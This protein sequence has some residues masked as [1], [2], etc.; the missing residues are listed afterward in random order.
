LGEVAW[1]ALPVLDETGTL[2]I[3]SLAS[4]E[5]WLDM[6]LSAAKP[7]ERQV[8]LRLQALNGAGVLD[9]PTHP[10]TVPPPE[11]SVEIALHVPAFAMAAPGDF[12]L[13]TWA[14]PDEAQL[15]DLLAHGNNVFAISLPAVNYDTQGRLGRS[16]YS[17][18]DPVLSRLRGQDVVLLLTGIP[19]LH[20]AP[21]SAAYRGDQKQ[22]LDE[23]VAHLAGAGFN[24]KHFALYPFDEP[25]GVG[26]SLINQLVE[27][28]KL[29]RAANPEVMIYVDGGGELSMF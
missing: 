3:P 19:S 13:C 26:W 24:T 5:L 9:A 22:F 10:H 14:A 23:L 15:P 29:V 25:G 7:G 6:D 12:R 17:K 28:G 11:T 16:D 2:S 20:G 18:L 4:R 8:K 1:D 27:F 21:D